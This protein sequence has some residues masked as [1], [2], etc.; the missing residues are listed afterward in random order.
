MV[1]RRHLTPRYRVIELTPT[2]YADA[3]LATR[4]DE[5]TSAIARR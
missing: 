2:L 1:F 3:M 4:K 5:V